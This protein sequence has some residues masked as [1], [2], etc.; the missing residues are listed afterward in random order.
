[1]YCIESIQVYGIVSTLG[2]T[3]TLIRVD[4]VRGTI[5]G[6]TLP[7]S[8][9]HHKLDYYP[10]LYTHPFPP[11][12][13]LT[14][15]AYTFTLTVYTTLTI[16]LNQHCDQDCRIPFYLHH[17]KNTISKQQL[18]RSVFFHLIYKDTG[19]DHNETLFTPILE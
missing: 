19:N 14:L 7:F 17:N 10:T 18:I 4:R 11:P 12:I 8:Y 2:L 6:I 13:T 1:M 16:P 3:F 9:L 5:R 15:Y